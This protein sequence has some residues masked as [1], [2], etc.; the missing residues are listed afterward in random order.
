MGMRRAQRAEEVGAVLVDG[1]L[2]GGGDLR[3]RLGC[4][5]ASLFFPSLRSCL[6][7]KQEFQK[8]A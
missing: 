4:S 6:L 2:S 8:L 3:A 1:A 7:Q 5:A